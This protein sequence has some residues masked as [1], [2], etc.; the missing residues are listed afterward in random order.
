VRWSVVHPL[1]SLSSRACPSRRN[2]RPRSAACRTTGQEHK[3]KTPASEGFLMGGTGLEPVTP[4]LSIRRSDPGVA[5]GYEDK[6]KRASSSSSRRARRKSPAY[7]PSS[8]SSPISSRPRPEGV[9]RGLWSQRSST[10]AS[11]A[12]STALFLSPISMASSEGGRSRSWMRFARPRQ[13]LGRRDSKLRGG[14]PPASDRCMFGLTSRS[15]HV[16]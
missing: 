3:R 10:S 1:G 14:T 13:R 12:D 5:T 11:F 6:S 16:P 9:E 2:L 4:S 7:K 15:P 8:S